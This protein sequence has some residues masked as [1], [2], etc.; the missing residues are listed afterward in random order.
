M[1]KLKVETALFKFK[2]TLGDITKDSYS[3]TQ[4][5]MLICFLITLQQS[6][7][8]IAYPAVLLNPLTLTYLNNTLILDNNYDF[9]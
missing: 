4:E 7:Y 1:A 3:H 2:A 8:G 5:L 9:L 6:G